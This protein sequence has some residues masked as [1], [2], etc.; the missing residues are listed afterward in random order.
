MKGFYIHTGQHN[1]T[2]TFMVLV[3]FKAAT[4]AFKRPKTAKAKALGQTATLG[5][6]K[7]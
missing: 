1:H 6:L 3:V 2:Q 7:Q 4:L 5:A